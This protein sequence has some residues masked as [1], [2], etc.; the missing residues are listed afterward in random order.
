ME[1]GRSFTVR[2]DEAIV[3][4]A[5]RA[6]VWRRLVRENRG[7][8]VAGAAMAVL[9]GYLAF[10]GDRSWLLGLFAV[11]AVA[12]LVLLGAGW[13]AHF[14]NS[15][16]KF[17]RMRAPEARFDIDA[18]AIRIAAEDGDAT[19]RWSA[20]TEI[21]ERPG[22]WMVFLAPNQFF[23]LPTEGLSPETLDV[24]RAHAGTM[25]VTPRPSADA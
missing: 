15:V 25:R 12:P 8:W 6:Y 20:V 9:T 4:A 1:T 13:R 10:T 22:A 17:R 21:W 19:I 24:V 5:V 3:R 14:V 16:G 23:L 18:E 2:Y 7:L 11:A